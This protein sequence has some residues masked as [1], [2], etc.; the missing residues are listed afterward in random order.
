MARK[1]EEDLPPVVQRALAAL[2]AHTSSDEFPHL[3]TAELRAFYHYFELGFI[4]GANGAANNGEQRAS[5]DIDA[6]H[7]AI[8]ELPKGW[9]NYA[10]TVGYN[11]GVEDR[12]ADPA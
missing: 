7:F 11:K 2:D 1:G 12:A 8:D 3:S 10:Y 9:G 5:A 4:D 6:G